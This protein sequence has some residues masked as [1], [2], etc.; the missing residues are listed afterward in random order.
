MNIVVYRDKEGRTIPT[1]FVERLASP[2][3]SFIIADYEQERAETSLD[4]AKKLIDEY[5]ER[6]FGAA[7]DYEDL[8]KVPIGHTTIGKEET[9]FQAYADLINCR[10][11]RYLDGN[12]ADRREYDCLE[13]M[14]NAE[15]EELDFAELIFFTNE[16]LDAARTAASVPAPAPVDRSDEMLQQALL[17]AE[18]SEQTGQ[19]VFGFEAGSLQ[20]V[21]APL[22]AAPAEKEEAPT[23]APPAPRKREKVSSFALHPEIPTAQRHEYRITDDQLGV[24]TP[25]ERYERNVAAIR[26]LKQIEGEDRLATPEEQAVLAQYVGW[27]GLA[28]CFDDRNSHYAELKALLTDEEYAAAR[29]STLT[30][31]YTPPTVIRAVYKALDNMGF[32]SGNILEPSCGVG[33]FLGMKPEKLAD[34]KIYGVELDS[35][36]GRIARQLYQQSSIAV[37]GYEKTDLPDSFF[38]VAL[39]NVPFGSFKV[40]TT[41]S[42][43]TISLPGRWIRSDRAASSRSSHPK[44]RWIRRAS[45]SANTSRSAPTCWARSV[46]PTPP[47][48]AQPARRSRR[49]SSFC[50][51]A[52]RSWTSCPTGYTSAKTGTVWS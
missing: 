34:S 2:P 42:F 40:S 47:S 48:R 25:S 46:C 4:H 33:N 39:G 37:Q 49:T 22:P 20:P 13:D 19:N 43:T 16:Q 26:T 5:C 36:S 6:E 17:A 7:G 41:S 11:D 31:F 29:E 10:I 28:D 3:R 9:V 27:G 35:I 30:A 12:L 21:N 32:Q 23:L 24:G 1:D 44:A 52:I 50:K 18:L 8:T 14:T 45:A 51:S 15:L 38:D